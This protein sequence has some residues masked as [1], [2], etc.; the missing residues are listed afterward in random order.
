MSQQTGGIPRL[1]EE[2]DMISLK[3]LWKTVFGD[4]A[5]D[6]DHFFST[7]FS[8]DLTTVI[9][10]GGKPVSAAYILPVGELVPACRKDGLPGDRR[11]PEQDSA[12]RRYPEQDRA[13]RRYPVAMLYAIA[14]HPDK[15]GRGYGEAVTRAAYAQALKKGYPAVVLKPADDGLFGFYEKRTD[16]REFFSVRVD[17]YAARELL[18]AGAAATASHSG[19]SGT[20]QPAGCFRFSFMPVSSAAY[21]HIRQWFLAGSSYIDFDERALSYQQYLC[22]KA[23]G[24]LYALRPG[25]AAVGNA[26]AAVGCAVI[27]PEGDAVCLKE[28]LLSPDCRAAD[29]VRAAAELLKAEKYIVRTMSDSGDEHNRRFGMMA[30]IRTCSNAPY[31]HSVKWYGPAFD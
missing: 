18:P 5:D 3:A 1:A 17:E 23:G 19:D 14:T 2:G 11:Y 9:D 27:E 10:D 31:V 29:A 26:G 13:D 12:I 15:R 30:P 8:P 22:Q 7:Y 4:D 28:L 20:E 25:G 6:I 16:F 21:R 24:G